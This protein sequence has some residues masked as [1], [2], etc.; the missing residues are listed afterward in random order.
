MQRIETLTAEVECRVRIICARRLPPPLAEKEQ[1][2]AE[3]VQ[4]AERLVTLAAQ[5][6]KLR[7]RAARTPAESEQLRHRLAEIEHE[8]KQARHEMDA[9]R[10]RKGELAAAHAKLQ[11]DFAHMASLV[12]TISA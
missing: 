4:I 10:D 6:A 12:S 8:L 5:N 3:N 11:S 9:A 7:T 1:R 2:E